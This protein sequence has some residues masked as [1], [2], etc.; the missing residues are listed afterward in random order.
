MAVAMSAKEPDESDVNKVWVLIEFNESSCE[1]S[2]LEEW[3]LARERE[4]PA[5]DGDLWEL[6]FIGDSLEEMLDEL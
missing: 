4:E 6:T 3:A 2:D 1:C 5:A